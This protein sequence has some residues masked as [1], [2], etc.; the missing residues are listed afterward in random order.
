MKSFNSRPYFNDQE[1][2]DDVSLELSSKKSS[3]KGVSTKTE[4]KRKLLMKPSPDVPSKQV[5]LELRDED[6]DDNSI[7]LKDLKK[8]TL[9][10]R[11]ASSKKKVSGT[12]SKDKEKIEVSSTPVE[13]RLSHRLTQSQTAVALSILHKS[14]STK[15]REKEWVVKASRNLL[16]KG[17]GI[18]QSLTFRN[19]YA[20]IHW[21]RILNMSFVR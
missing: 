7:S 10:K 20:K 13:Q 12:C 19:N 16:N 6:I 1:N 4:A 3:N 2:R 14:T 5:Q 9:K 17:K 21:E 8:K 11:D 18:S 15:R